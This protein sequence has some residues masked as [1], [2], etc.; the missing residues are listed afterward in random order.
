MK[1]RHHIF[2]ILISLLPGY[3]T[4]YLYYKNIIPV[5]CEMLSN[6]LIPGFFIGMLL[7]GGPHGNVSIHTFA[8]GLGI[9]FYFI[10]L[11]SRMVYQK[12]KK[13]N[14]VREQESDIK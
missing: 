2:I 3:L 6:I 4:A 11:V 9:E 13:S 10:W 7:G 14:Y 1:P 12:Y 8:V 5:C